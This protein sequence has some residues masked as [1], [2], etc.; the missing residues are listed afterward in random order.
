MKRS[1]QFL[2]LIASLWPVLSS[3]Q[4][5]QVYVSTPSGIAV[6]NAAS[7]G[8]L[9]A[10]KGSPFHTTAGQVSDSLVLNGNYLFAIAPGPTNFF[11][12]ID[13]FLIESSGAIKFLSTTNTIPHVKNHNGYVL[14]LFS[15]KTGSTVYAGV[16]GQGTANLPFLSYSVEKE[17]GELNYTGQIQSDLAIPFPLAFSGSNHYAYGAGCSELKGFERLSD[18]VLIYGHGG[19]LPEPAPG[20][21]FCAVQNPA[22]DATDHVVFVVDPL[23][24]KDS[25]PQLATYSV[26]SE[27]RLT[28]SSTYRNMPRVAVG[29]VSSIQLSPEGNLLAVGGTLGLQIFHFNGSKPISALTGLLNKTHAQFSDFHWDKHNHLYAIDRANQKLYVYTV[30]PW[31][32]VQAPGSPYTL[33]AYDLAV[34]NLPR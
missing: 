29:T 4:V 10:I 21:D 33:N 25:R 17:T 18:G 22:S 24:G 11:T 19:P 7:D 3:A 9:T 1:L 13:S 15:D 31:S 27:G 12:N 20:T 2:C 5:A 8:K 23:G 30:T 26:E 16:E 34:Q 32:V 28:T 14:S 6:Y